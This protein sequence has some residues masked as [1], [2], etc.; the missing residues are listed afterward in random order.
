MAEYIHISQVR[1]A[2]KK[3]HRPFRVSFW[4]RKGAIVDM[5][6]C[7]SL[8]YDV[9]HGTRLIKNVVSREKRTIYDCCIFMFNDLKVF[10]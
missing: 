4:T 3:D 10:I 9:R 8:R 5:Q 2:L 1:E 7:I 6:N